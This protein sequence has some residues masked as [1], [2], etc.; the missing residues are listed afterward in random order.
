MSHTVT[1][2]EIS[3][4]T[5]DVKQ[6]KVEKPEGYRY[7][8]GQATEVAINEEGWE[9]EKRPFTFTNLPDEDHLEFVIKIYEDHDGVTEQLG[10]LE[11]GAELIIG[12]AWGTIQY[13][14]SGVFIAGG[15]GV[16]P[17]IC[18]LRDLRER[19]KLDGHTLLFS[20]KT[21]ED[22]ILKEEF[23][24]MLGENFINTLTREDLEHYDHGRLNK[25]RLDGYIDD[26]DQNFYVCGPMQF[27]LDM[28]NA[29]NDLG[30]DMDSIV[31]EE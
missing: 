6:F 15:A 29:L 21:E 28:S 2:Q 13:E 31:L 3:Q 12:D 22:I 14:G 27:V 30:A 17:F 8:P 4:V 16:T 7:E 25:E 1:I 23:E 9:D 20:N 11:P 10:M 26:F 5:H 24:E 19:D 18:I